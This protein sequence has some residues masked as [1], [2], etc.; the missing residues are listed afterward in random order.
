MLDTKIVGGTIVDGTGAPAFVGDVGIRDGRVVAVG[1]V[2]EDASEVIDAEGCI[3]APGLIDPHTH[4][5]AQLFWDP[6]ASPSN[7]HGVTTVIGGNCGFT[8]APLEPGDGD[9][10]RRLMAKVE[11]MDLAA[12]ENGLDWDW[13]SF[14]D[15]IGRLDGNI[16]VNAGFLVGHCAIRRKVMGADAVGQEA[17]EAQVVE[18]ERLLAESIE[19]GGLGFST[20]RGNHQDGNGDPVPSRWAT[21]EEILRLCRVTGQHEGTTLEVILEGCLDK[22][23]DDEIE[24]ITAMS[25]EGQRPVNWNVLTVDSAAPDR[26]PRQLGAGEYAASKGGR[27]VALTMPTIVGMNMSFGTFCA[28]NLIPGWGDI[29]DLPLEER[30]EK[31]RDP[32]VRE[33]MDTISHSEQAGV[34]RRLADWGGYRIGDTF[35]DENQPLQRR[36]VHEIAEERGT[37]HFDTLVD[38]VLADDLRTV[39]WPS[40]TD[41]DDASWDL[42]QQVWDHPH[43]MLGGSDAGAH[44]DRMCGAPYGTAFL[45]DT[46][47]GRKLVSVERAIQMLTSEPA[48]LFGLRDRGVLREGAHADVFVFEPDE[49]GCEPIYLRTDLPGD[50]KRLYSEPLGVKR[51]MVNGVTTVIDGEQVEGALP[52][53][54][55]KPGRDTETVLP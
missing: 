30:M 53:T 3:V 15:W 26:H 10:L 12:L 49:V 4:Y 27:V 13:Q 24:F 16:G 25:V 8:I 11:G 46:L 21:D 52:G 55:L 34:F 28:F 47:R 40:P 44:L 20:G 50:G 45:R 18:M 36:Y 22:F 51:V 29:L 35:S 32:A 5:D 42:R 54:V 31:L 39:L 17:S 1:D 2:S 41:N 19:A 38:I 37:G 48:E 7:I 23:A 6:Y 14:G 9:Y 43:S 33:M